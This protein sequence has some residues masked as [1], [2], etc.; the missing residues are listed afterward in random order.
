MPILKWVGGKGQ[1]LDRIMEHVPNEIRVY[2]EPFLGGGAVLL[3]VLRKCRAGE[4]RVDRFEVGDS[5]RHLVSM[6]EAVRDRPTELKEELETMRDEYT[7]AP[8]VRWSRETHALLDLS[9]KES[10]ISAGKAYY[11]YHV[12][13][14]FNAE[15]TPARFV[16]LNKTGFRGMYRESKHG[17]FNV[18]FGNYANPLVC[19]T[20]EIDDLHVLLAEFGVQVRCETFEES[21]AR[22]G[23]GDF[24]YVDPPYYDT[25]TAYTSSGFGP[26]AQ[27]VLRVA[28]DRARVTGAGWMASNSDCLGVRSLYEGCEMEEILAKRKIHSKK[29]GSMAGELLIFDAL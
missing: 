10:C 7:R 3:E 18:P 4:M 12:R 13:E 25:F 2:R 22:A 24:I 1:M 14:R 15:P 23:P 29:P 11:Y 8:P 27:A 26:E 17:V 19:P 20:K 16:F 9:D 5:N 6:Y 21:L 28:L